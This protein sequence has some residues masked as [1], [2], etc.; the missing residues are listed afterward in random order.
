MDENTAVG[1]HLP[2]GTADWFREGVQ[3]D[4]LDQERTNWFRKFETVDDNG[5]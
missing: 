2:D 5:E 4:Y 3:Q 1:V